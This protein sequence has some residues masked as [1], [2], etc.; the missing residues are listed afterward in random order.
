MGTYILS[1]QLSWDECLRNTPNLV[2]YIHLYV[3]GPGRHPIGKIVITDNNNGSNRHW[4]NLTKNLINRTIRKL[5]ISENV[6]LKS[7]NLKEIKNIMRWRSGPNSTVFYRNRKGAKG[8][9]RIK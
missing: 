4:T 8:V 9:K 5:R 2:K 3:F 1:I 6:D 7:H